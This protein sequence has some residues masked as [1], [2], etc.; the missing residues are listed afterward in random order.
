[1]P[2]RASSFR[3]FNVL[4]IRVGVDASWFVVLF[5][6]IFLL[7]AD[8]RRELSASDGVAYGT[9]VA[10]ALLF[11]GSIVLHELGHALAARRMGIDTLSIDLWFFGG[12][13]R[14]SR[15]ARTPGEEF[16]MAAAGPA[17]TLL[18]V[19]VCA[20]GGIALAGASQFWDAAGIGA[21]SI[22]PGLLLLAWLATVNVGLLIFNLV[23]AYPL[24]GGRLA[25]AGVWRLTG[26]R[27][28]ATRASARIG[29][30]FAWLL[31][32]FGLVL[33]LG[34]SFNGLYLLVFAFL[35]GSSARAAVAQSVVTDRLE[36]VRVADIM[37]PQA[38]SIPGHYGADQAR[39]DFFDRY[40]WDWFPVVDQSGRHV[41]V[42][43]ER[44]VAAAPAGASA[45]DVADG[46]ADWTVPEET[47]LEEMVASEP[48]RSHGGL[49]TVDGEGRVRGV[50]TLGRVRRA[51]SA[52]VA[53]P[54]L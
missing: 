53:S 30:A 10:A 8:F 43:R 50:L 46:S 26:D 37:D 47:S 51:L 2:R 40:G 48:L 33:L 5:V 44:D 24:D 34:G 38:V 35:F 13:A 22:S 11:F 41:G 15:D 32:A 1:M 4:G 18:I 28:R 31:G 3:L 54:A 27:G 17:V 20:G 21:D 7:S 49:V 19:L 36:G 25:R 14:L 45:A 39:L 16:K 42:L 23:P 29:Q 12:L 52:A 6:V 9:A